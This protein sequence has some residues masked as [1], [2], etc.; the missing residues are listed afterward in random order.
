MGK[1]FLRIAGP[2][3]VVMVICIVVSGALAYLYE[4]VPLTGTPQLA[5]VIAFYVTV[6]AWPCLL[7]STLVRLLQYWQQWR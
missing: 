4:Q 2:R 6:C 1:P 7:V 5:V 3:L